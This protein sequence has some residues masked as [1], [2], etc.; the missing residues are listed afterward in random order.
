[1][2]T[3]HGAPSAVPRGLGAVSRGSEQ[4]TTPG[5]ALA[6]RRVRGAGS[7]H[8]KHMAQA[9]IRGHSAR[10]STSIRLR[11]GAW[12]GD[13]PV[14]LGLPESWDVTLFAPRTGAVLDDAEIQARLDSPIDQPAI[15]ERCSARTRPLIIV[16][17]LNRPTP[18]SRVLPPLVR[19]FTDAGVPMRNITIM[20]GSGT[21][22]PPT[23]DAVAK[24][25]GDLT[26]SCRVCANDR[27]RDLVKVG[28][29]SFGTPVLVPREVVASNFLV[30]V[31]GVYPNHTGGFG[32]G[33]KA[34]LGI[35]GLRSISALHFGHESAG[36]G[37]HAKDA[38]FRRDLDEIAKLI[39][40]QTGVFVV[41]D[42]DRHIVDLACGDIFE[43]YNRFVMSTKDAFRAPRP[44]P[45][46]RI[47]IS[48]AYPDD[49]SLTFLR[50]KGTVPLRL[51]PR[52]ASRIV[53]ATCSEGLGF[54][55]LFPF[56]N[57]PPLHRQR[58]LLYRVAANVNKPR[59]FAT[60]A[61]GRVVR[62][63]IASRRRGRVASGHPMW[64]YCPS[65]QSAAMLPCSV[66]G[67]RMTSSWS[68]ILE[69]VA[70]EQNHQSP[71]RTSVY[72][73]APLQWL[74]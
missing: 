16:D 45:G 22:A 39:G 26:Y 38:T 13:Q 40:L 49:L 65:R 19:Q 7:G 71:L 48:N 15:R 18:A 52:A 51:A 58:M 43:V 72:T 36:W 41:V 28:R 27:N 67:F 59:Q 12:Y 20:V 47:V 62:S 57:A 30:A 56:L 3:G 10:R 73:A 60:K 31:G 29:T 55:G 6:T 5:E 1:M 37:S 32:G 4:E 69:G 9:A 70:A 33:S 23:A 34:A 11:T 42:A 50:M 53:V 74:E 54:H 46:V 61:A 2:S 44:D 17:D 63:P 21:H 68:E 14:E 35:L 25:V 66:P 8:K 64:L 24:K